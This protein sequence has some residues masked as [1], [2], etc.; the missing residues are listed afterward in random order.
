MLSL[1]ITLLTNCARLFA[2]K[3]IEIIS[4]L[5]PKR[6]WYELNNSQFSCFYHIYH[7]IYFKEVPLALCLTPCRSCRPTRTCCPRAV[8]SCGGHGPCWPAWTLWQ[9]LW[10]VS[11]YLARSRPFSPRPSAPTFRSCTLPRSTRPGSGKNATPRRCTS[12]CPRCHRCT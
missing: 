3:K 12:S 10:Y 5:L 7:I 1:I 4:P 6:V 11:N 8:Q 2:T 9:L